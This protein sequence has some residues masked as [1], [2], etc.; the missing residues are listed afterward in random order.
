MTKNRSQGLSALISNMGEARS[1]LIDAQN[2][3]GSAEKENAK[4]MESIEGRTQLL[5]N[6]LQELAATTIN[7][8]WLKDMVSLLDN[9]VQ[10]VTGLTKGMSGLSTVVGTAF[11]AI[12]TVFGKGFVNL[13][14][15]GTGKLPLQIVNAVQGINALRSSGGSV[16]NSQTF[17]DK[18]LLDLFIASQS[19][20]T[21]QYKSMKD[22]VNETFGDWKNFFDSLG[23][24]A[25]ESLQPFILSIE[26]GTARVGDVIRSEAEGTVQFVNQ[27]AL[28]AQQTIASIKSTALTSIKAIGSALINI[29]ISMAAIWVATK[30]I[31]ALL[32]KIKE[33]QPETIIENGKKARQELDEL[34][35]KVK[36]L[37]E[38]VKDI[39][40]KVEIK[41]ADT[42][43]TK[44]NLQELAK[45]YG[46]L[47]KGVDKFS[48]ANKTLSTKKYQDYL[49]ICNKLAEQ[50]P[51]LVKGYDEQGNAVLNLGNEAKTA[52]E[53]L[54]LVYNAALDISNIDMTSKLVESFSGL[55]ESAKQAREEI[56]KINVDNMNIN[57]DTE[58][59][60][61]RITYDEYE[62][63]FQL[64]FTS[65]EQVD[66]WREN[67]MEALNLTEEEF[68]KKFG[69][70]TTDIYA[71]FSDPFYVPQKA[72][73]QV[74]Q[75]DY[76]WDNVEAI[77][78]A[79]PQ[80]M[81]LDEKRTKNAEI[82]QNET[83]IISL[84][85]SIVAG[86]AEFVKELT[87]SLNDNSIFT[88]LNETL[89]SN[90]L[91]SLNQFNLDEVVEY[92]EKEYGSFN[93]LL[94]QGVWYN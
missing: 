91:T 53:Q 42:N 34:T 64:S 20:P 9:A 8:E 40:I 44:K 83:R 56:E 86:Q 58:E 48:N 89:T 70:I 14:N 27:Q 47:I 1:A 57:S 33:N 5:Q 32:E 73:S 7:T 50:Y 94:A 12:T 68:R 54:L 16:L 22:L 2:A 75:G 62:P 10:L 17:N 63:Y 52:S 51:E 11:G 37:N 26:N 13:N 21:N 15:I 88:S 45:K 81:S 87:E 66:Q 30:A 4:Y 46:E 76:F 6:H 79:M 31:P 29:G 85:N 92:I 65:V 80:N 28:S 69:E 93:S 82:A 74:I 24:D 61:Y 25:Q 23:K 35:D 3:E 18:N 71:Q 41:N 60:G 19:D 72:Y 43:S 36:K 59:G 77:I 78:G 49:D 39:A 38:S 55:Y 90:V 67:V 84:R